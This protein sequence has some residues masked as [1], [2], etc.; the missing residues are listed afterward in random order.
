MYDIWYCP[1]YP[2]EAIRVS[3]RVPRE[4][5]EDWRLALA[6]NIQRCGLVNP[7]IEKRHVLRA[8]FEGRTEQILE[9]V[10]GEIDVPFEIA[11]GHFRFYHPELGKM[12]RGV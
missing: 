6:E 11:E 5:R 12:S 8:L 7:L 10:D 9:I 4:G 1:E 2:V 3:T